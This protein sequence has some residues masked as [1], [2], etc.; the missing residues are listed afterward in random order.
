MDR[1]II[2]QLMLVGMGGF[3]GSTLRFLLGGWVQRALPV[4]QFPVGTM[5]VN[6][7]G[8][9]CIGYLGGLMEQRQLL[10]S[11]LRLFLLV[12]LLGGFTTFSTFAFESLA[13]TQDSQYLKL[14][15]NVVGQVVMGF[16]AAWLGLL[17]ARL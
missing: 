15:L 14:L 2:G 4:G 11:G 16:T 10:D 7:L 17:A 1:I 13:L 6:V 12:G 5:A 8:C 9:L 3:L